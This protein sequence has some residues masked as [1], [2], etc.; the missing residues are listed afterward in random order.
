MQ[1]FELSIQ[2]VYAT[3]NY[4]PVFNPIDLTLK[5]GDSLYLKGDNGVGKTTFLRILTGLNPHYQ[6]FITLN[7]NPQ[8]ELAHLYMKEMIY[9]GHHLGLKED[10]TPLENIRLLLNINKANKSDE[11]ILAVFETLN[12]PAM[13]R[14]VRFLSAGQKRRVA[15]SRLW[16]EEKTC[17]ILDEPFTALDLKTIEL[18]ENK[19]IQHS[20]NNGVVIFTSH[21]L[22]NNNV[23][24]KSFTI[25][26]CDKHYADTF[27]DY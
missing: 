15:L 16:L 13:K 24:N 2:K 12:V 25:S 26:P 17:W 14:A 8:K 19:I 5:N 27:S 3:R 7:N 1:L 23:Y 4:I 18:L 21:Q 20:E 10:L 6:G 11:E 9:I 22:P